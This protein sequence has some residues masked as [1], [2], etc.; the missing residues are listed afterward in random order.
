MKTYLRA[1]MAI[2]LDKWTPPVLDKPDYY[3]TI[4]YVYINILIYMKT[5]HMPCAFDKWDSNAGQMNNEGQFN[6]LFY[7]YRIILKFYFPRVKLPALFKLIL[8]YLQETGHFYQHEI[9]SKG[10]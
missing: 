2:V 7:S 6:M 4:R 1:T 10:E 3:I 9:K 5:K 8:G